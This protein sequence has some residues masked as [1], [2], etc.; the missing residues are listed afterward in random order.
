MDNRNQN[1]VL[2][3]SNLDTN[4]HRDRYQEITDLEELR[5]LLLGLNAEQI[6]QLQELLNNNSIVNPEAISRLLPDA[7]QLRTQRDSLLG[8]AMVTTVEQA[9]QNS[10]DRD[11]ETLSE[12]I[13]PIIVPA[14]RKAVSNALEE[15]V[16]SLNQTLEH[17][18]SP[19]SMRW[20][21]EAQR[22]GKSFAEI[23]LLRTLEYRVEQVFLIHRETGLLLKHIVA[24]AV[25][26]QDPDLVSAM[27]T[28]IQD[29]MRDSFRVDKNEGL[30][31]LQFGELTIWVE[32]SPRMVLAGIIRGNA[33]LDLRE[34]F[35][36]AIAKIH[37]QFNRQLVEFA[38]DT[39][40]FEATEP[41]LNPCFAT[42]YK[43]Q[44]RKN[45]TY[46]LVFLGLIFTLLGIWGFLSWRS[47]QRWENFVTLVRS[48]PGIVINRTGKENGKYILE[49][50]RD[51]FAVDPMQ[52]LQQTEIDPQDVKSTW[53]AFISL[54]P[55]MVA[56]R[57]A[58]RMKPPD[59]VNIDIDSQGNITVSGVAPQ[60]WIRQ[61]RQM[62]QTI[63][64][65]NSY[66]DSQLSN[67]DFEQLNRYK[68]ALEKEILRFQ[69]GSSELLPEDKPKLGSIQTQVKII[70]QIAKTLNYN[71]KLE[72]IGHTDRTGSDTTN[73]S[74]SQ[75]RAAAI[76]SALISGGIDPK[77][78]T[79]KGVASQSPI[80][81][82]FSP[83][84]ASINRR[85]SFRM[86]LTKNSPQ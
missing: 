13:F 23:V 33:P 67:L 10:V 64:G 14:T 56:R 50:M 11:V 80:D 47:H 75:N 51:P 69:N 83:T 65:I 19:Q 30:Q 6:E 7:V 1:G 63:S 48:Q 24:P 27:L 52:F 16:Q 12:S 34:V 8:E 58:Q 38:G 44:K 59:T 57:I 45:N 60:A 79:I 70:F 53:K 36:Q 68:L 21:W 37:L 76:A 72:I 25:T 49:G 77:R 85:V 35:Q 86:F 71:A 5:Q 81:I 40:P 3:Q 82:N 46:A 31:S 41:L 4:N 20:R 17:S 9:I 66:N 39:E 28:A 74:L 22:T 54:E 61:S 73:K 18:L 62:W 26:A 55:E 15:M 42:G 84:D 2:S 43:T 29:F 32:A 78:I